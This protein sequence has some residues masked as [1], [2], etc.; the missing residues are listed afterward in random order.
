MSR[1]WFIFKDKLHS[2]EPKIEGFDELWKD[3]VVLAGIVDVDFAVKR[4]LWRLGHGTKEELDK[5]YGSD[6]DYLPVIISEEKAMEYKKLIERRGEEHL[7]L[8]HRSNKSVNYGD[9][10]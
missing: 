6:P 7:S 10:E 1:I 2:I 9:K 5:E 3:P 8:V 4:D